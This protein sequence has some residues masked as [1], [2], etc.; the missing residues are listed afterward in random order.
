M[1]LPPAASLRPHTPPA[2]LLPAARGRTLGPQ[3]AGTGESRCRGSA[4]RCCRAPQGQTAAPGTCECE[5][6][7]MVGGT[8]A[9]GFRQNL[10]A[11]QH[12]TVPGVDVCLC[13]TLHLLCGLK[14]CF[15]TTWVAN[16]NNTHTHRMMAARGGGSMKSKLATSSIPNAW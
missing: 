15:C 2:A 9:C 12:T 7:V 14:V 8:E 1:P 4:C 6:C 16:A 3:A 11:C 13:V 5:G 10:H